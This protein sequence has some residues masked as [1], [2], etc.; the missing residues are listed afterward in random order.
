MKMRYLIMEKVWGFNCFNICVRL[1]QKDK[2][3]EYNKNHP[4]VG[5]KIIWYKPYTK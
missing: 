1:I 3:E 4:C 5:E 2:I